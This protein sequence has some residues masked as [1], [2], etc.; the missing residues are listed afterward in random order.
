VADR[1]D[2]ADLVD[3]GLAAAT[4]RRL[5]RS[6]PRLDADE[7]ARIV[8]ELHALAADAAGHVERLTQ[9][10]PVATAGA[11]VVVDRRAWASSNIEGL[12]WV[13]RPLLDKLVASR[14]PSRA[15]LAVS[16]RIAGVQ[17]GTALAFL[18]TRVLGQYELFLPDVPH[19][20]LA[21]VAPNIAAAERALGADSRDF[22]M[23]VCLHEQC[24]RVQFTAVPWLRGHLE[25]LVRR[26][27]DA[28]DLDPA[29]LGVRL[30]AAVSALRSHETTLIEALQTPEQR[31]VV[32]EIQALMTLLEGHADWAMD[33][34]GEGLIPTLPE[35]RERLDQ[36]RAHGGG[37][38]DTLL[39][40][41]FGLDAKL[42]QYKQGGDFVRAVVKVS[43]VG[44]LNTVWESPAALP[45][46]AE[47]AD[48]TAWLRRVL[49]S[50]VTLPA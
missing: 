43:G 38:L 45:T 6:G 42:A 18:S 39:R 7:A 36:R 40:K 5:A 8:S 44:G 30:R 15:A 12:R 2:G 3:W 26:L 33:A 17:L 47:L 13:T 22:R 34:A 4:A 16:R 49:G 19:G 32:D 46:R 29:A 14:P 50:A 28:T 27:A 37:L 10:V 21:L 48:P 11:T 31:V 25:G 9:M 35:I 23:W 24:H 1:V 20:R 41:L